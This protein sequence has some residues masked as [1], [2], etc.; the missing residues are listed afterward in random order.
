MKARGIELVNIPREGH[1]RSPAV[2]PISTTP[3]ATG[4]RDHHLYK[5]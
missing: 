2:T 1:T 3:M 4:H 5:K